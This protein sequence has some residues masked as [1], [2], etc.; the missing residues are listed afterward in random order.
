MNTTN[1]AVQTIM[2]NLGEL[3]ADQDAKIAES[4]VAWALARKAAL[5]AFEATD[6]ARA[7]G[8][9]GAWGGIYEK[10]FEICG[11]KTWFQLFSTASDDEIVTTMQKKAKHVAEA[12]NAKIA[13]K[14]EKAGVT[15]VL[16]AEAVF[17][18]DGFRGVYKVNGERFVEIQ[19]IVAGGYNVQRLHQRVLCHVR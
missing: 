2:A 8:K 10:R 14:L 1:Q 12:R 4:D 15:E 9:L 13:T 16:Q 3:F 11:G 19:S 17:I 6:E 7:L 18:L 5:R